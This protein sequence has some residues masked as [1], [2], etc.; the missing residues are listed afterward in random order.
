[1]GIRAHLQKGRT[2][3]GLTL[4]ASAVAQVNAYK[5]KS[6]TE[7]WLGKEA[8][9]SPNVQKVGADPS[10]ATLTSAPVTG[11]PDQTKPDL[12]AQ[13]RANAGELQH[14]AD[15]AESNKQLT[16]DNM[17]E[18]DGVGEALEQKLYEAGY[19]TYEAL[20]EADKAGLAE[21]SGISD[22]MAKEIVKQ[23]KKLAKAKAK[24]AAK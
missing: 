6:T 18:I 12:D 23:A 16:P 1:M 3:P 7:K 13:V 17:T 5:D 9:P 22:D 24:T 14:A 10:K 11:G 4:P 19:K 15:Q 21:I 20:A 8:Q 2:K